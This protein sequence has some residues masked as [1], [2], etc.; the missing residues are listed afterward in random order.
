[1]RSAGGGW[2]K[3]IPPPSDQSRWIKMCDMTSP[4]VML[5]SPLCLVFA[6]KATFSLVHV[7]VAGMPLPAWVGL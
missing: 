1:M 3:G 4:H 7:C 2:G 6:W 5:P